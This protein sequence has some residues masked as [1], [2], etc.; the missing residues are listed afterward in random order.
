MAPS[1]R[2]SYFYYYYWKNRN[3][4]SI[5]A[6]RCFRCKLDSFEQCKRQ[7]QIS[8]AVEIVP[9]KD[10]FRNTVGATVDARVGSLGEGGEG[11]GFLK[12]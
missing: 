5:R 8:G 11:G 3:F 12:I 4:P 10:N 9:Y 1:K 6:I 2:L 7:L